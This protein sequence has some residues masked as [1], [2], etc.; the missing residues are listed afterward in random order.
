MEKLQVLEALYSN[1]SDTMAKCGFAPEY[2]DGMKKTGAPVYERG[3]AVVMDLTGEKGVSRFVFSEDRI[4]L[5]F[6]DKDAPRDDDSAFTKDTT[7]L[8]VL[9]EYT[10]KDIKSIA[11]EVND[12]MTETFVVKKKIPVKTKDISTVSRSAAKSGALAYDPIT[13]A[14]KLSAIYPE[15]KE[16]ITANIAQYG[17]FLCE[18][19][20][21][22]HANK[23]IEA[24]IR[25][26][27]PQRMKRLFNIICEIYEDGTN[28]VQSLI[29]VTA[30]GFIENDPA[31]VQQIMPYLTDSMLEPVLEVSKR[32]KNS[33][34]AKMRL[35]N[36]PKYKP[37]KQKKKSFLDSLMGGTSGIQQ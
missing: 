18:D 31:L 32:L 37:P 17:E 16:A 23:H 2:K 6:A 27:N 9:G 33:K 26:N 30:L 13:F 14:T 5:L 19:F 36:P 4:H 8:F 29:A 20:F 34:S 1:I 15:L 3:E 7:Y 24:T 25:E 28:E 35:E 11:V 21:L 22:T 12:Y 10:E